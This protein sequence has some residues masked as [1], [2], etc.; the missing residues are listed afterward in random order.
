[1]YLIILPQC[2]SLP[3]QVPWCDWGQN[4]VWL[5]A[6]SWGELMT[7]WRLRYIRIR[8][9]QRLLQFQFSIINLSKN[10]HCLFSS[11]CR[12]L[13]A[14]VLEEELHQSAAHLQT[15]SQTGLIPPWQ[16][17]CSF[18]HFL[19]H[20]C[21]DLSFYGQINNVK[22]QDIQCDKNKNDKNNNKKTYPWIFPLVSTSFSLLLFNFPSNPS[23]GNSNWNI[24]EMKPKTRLVK[25]I[26]TVK[27]GNEHI[28]A[29]STVRPCS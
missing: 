7:C 12:D 16:D 14:S 3:R 5:S 29:T 23:K 18:L 25:I 19:N 28:R 20:C 24:T 4:R 1:M 27:N 17:A 2:Q 21:C 22:H 6:A 26:L 9:H 15:P 8:W 10:S 13:Q 11:S